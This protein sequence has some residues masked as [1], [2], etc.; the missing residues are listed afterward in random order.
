MQLALQTL[1]VETE[2]VA[3]DERMRPPNS[4]VGVLLSDPSLAAELLGWKPET[5]LEQ[6]IA[7]TAQWLEQN[8]ARYNTER[9]GY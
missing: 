1:G 7:A 9:Y 6:G 8:L 2:I 3:E 5:S 4:E